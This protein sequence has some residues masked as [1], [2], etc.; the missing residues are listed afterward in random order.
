MRVLLTQL[1]V[2]NNPVTNTPLAAGYLKAYAPY[3]GAA[4]PR[5]ARHSA[6]RD[7]GPR[8][9][10][11][12]RR[13]DRRCRAGPARALAV[14]LEQRADAGGRAAGPRPAPRAAG[15]GWR[16]RVPGGQSLGAGTPGVDIAVIGEGEQTFAALLTALA[17]SPRPLS[18]AWERGPGVRAATLTAIPGLALRAADGSVTLTAPRAPLDDL[19]NLPSPYLLGYLN[20]TP[21]SGMLLVEVSRWCPYACSFCL[22]GRNMGPKLG[23]RM[24]GLSSCWPRSAGAGARRHQ[25]PL[26]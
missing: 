5:P 24:F 23:G 11:R 1:P 25:R 18:Q 20:D 21:A 16:A 13:G 19:T 17:P 10:F 3:P 14:H 15:G 26:H 8:R 22:Y 2:P 9:R 6:A 7:R 4:G 12:A